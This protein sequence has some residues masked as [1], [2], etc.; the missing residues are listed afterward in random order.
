MKKVTKNRG[1]AKNE[2]PSKVPKKQRWKLVLWV[3]LLLMWVFV[4]VVA[5]ELVVGLIMRAILGAKLTDPVW[6]GVY[7]VIAYGLA[8]FLVLWVPPRI[9]MKWKIDLGEFPI[10]K[11]KHIKSTGKKQGQKLS[12]E[13]LGLHGYLTWTDIGLSVVGYVVATLVAAGLVW[14]FSLFPWF[15][16]GEAQNTGFTVF[17]NGGERIIAFLVLV[18]VAPILEE[19]IFRGWL[20][21]KL[22]SRLSAPLSILLVSL[23]F[24]LMHFQWNVGVNVFALSVVLCVMRELTGTIYAGMLT[25]MIKNGIAFYL[26]Y[27]LGM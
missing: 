1:E 2:A 10:K 11:I 6:N 27:V 20:Y 17:M 7:A 5:S 9:G 16:A 23:L 13:V 8:L 12:R 14:V 19:T 3:A 21:G 24:G 18:V 15:D 22:R 25:H 4:S 26:L